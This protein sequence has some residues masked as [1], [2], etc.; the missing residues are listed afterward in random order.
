MKKKILS[1]IFAIC[2]IIPCA[3]MLSACGKDDKEYYTVHIYNTNVLFGENYEV[4]VEKGSTYGDIKVKSLAG[5]TLNNF[6]FVRDRVGANWTI[7]DSKVEPDSG[8]QVYLYANYKANDNSAKLTIDGLTAEYNL[9]RGLTVYNALSKAGV[10]LNDYN[11]C[12]W[13]TDKELINPVDSDIIVPTTSYVTL[14][15]NRC[16]NIDNALQFSKNGL[17]AE[18]CGAELWLRGARDV[19]VPKKHLFEDESVGRT[20]TSFKFADDASFGDITI[21]GTVLSVFGGNA[22]NDVGYGITSINL[23]EGVESFSANLSRSSITEIKI[24]S[25]LTSFT[26][27]LNGAKLESIIVAEGNTKYVSKCVPVSMVVDPNALVEIDTLKLVLGCKN[28]IIF[29]RGHVNDSWIGGVKTIG[30]GAFEGVVFTKDIEFPTTLETI[31][32]RAFYNCKGL[33]KVVLWDGIKT[34]AEE[35]FAS[36]FSDSD[37]KRIYIPS[38][39]ISI[40]ES[41]FEGVD[42]NTAIIYCGVAEA[43]SGYDSE[44]SLNEIQWNYADKTHQLATKYGYSY[45]D[46]LSENS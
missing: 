4:K 9:E 7:L 37:L 6:S 2:L 10:E 27:K 35:A 1:F 31:E 42:Y 32:S 17:N 40:G 39:V 36:P 30:R 5:Y 15:T 18:T 21:P 29:E 38:T 3:V 34:I 22:L 45:A 20:I 24:P 14:A 11:T 46:F 41:V 12:G 43:P 33:N 8:D 44:P 16:K 13:F 19:V 26:G 23:P 25:T 28:S